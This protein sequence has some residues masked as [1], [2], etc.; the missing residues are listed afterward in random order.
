[1][2]GSKGG[3]RND[4][5]E[6]D[7]VDRK[8]WGETSLGGTQRDREKKTKGNWEGCGTNRQTWE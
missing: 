5:E 6:V 8:N 2:S 7:G 1:M 4:W 3:N